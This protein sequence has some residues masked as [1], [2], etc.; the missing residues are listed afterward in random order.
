MVER[1]ERVY[2]LTDEEFDQ[3]ILALEEGSVPFSEP[4]MLKKFGET[5]VSKLWE[6][7]DVPAESA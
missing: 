4:A 5:I 6:A 3:A 7:T 2:K 1:V